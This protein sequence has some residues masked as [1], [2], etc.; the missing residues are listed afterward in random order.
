MEKRAISRAGTGAKSTRE[1]P[2]WGRPGALHIYQFSIRTNQQ[3]QNTKLDVHSNKSFIFFSK[4]F[5]LKNFVHDCMYEML[6]TS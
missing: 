3:L 1:R 4:I 5:R 2:L 6:H